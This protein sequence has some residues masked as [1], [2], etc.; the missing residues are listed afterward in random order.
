MRG[1]ILTPALA[2]Y[3]P[4]KPPVDLARSLVLWGMNAYVTSK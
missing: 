3:D 4:H 2:S 1:Q